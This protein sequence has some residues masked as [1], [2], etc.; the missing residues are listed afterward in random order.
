MRIVVTGGAGFIGS[1]FVRW[2]LESDPGASVVTLDALTYAGNAENL[3]G[4]DPDRHRLVV[5][6]VTR[7]D[8]V[9]G[10]LDGHVDAVVHFAAESHVDRSILGAQAFATTNVVGTQVVLDAVRAARVPRLLYVSTDE[11]Y[12]SLAPGDA[13][14]TEQHPLRPTSPYAASKAGADLLVLAAAATHG[15]D[16][17]I[18]RCGNNYGP[19]QFPEKLIPLF[20]TNALAGERLPLYGDGRQV[21]D[22]IHVHDHCR[23]LGT[24]LQRGRAGRVYNVGAHGERD[25]LAL[26]QQ[27]MA[28]LDV[29]EDR[30]VHVADRPAHDRRY[31]LDTR[32]I[33]DELGF[34]PV[35][36]LD[37]GLAATVAW[38]R[39]HRDWWERVK[40]G[41][42]RTYYAAQY[43][44]RLS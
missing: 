7:P 6:D 32:R 44:E 27:L 3:G 24:V 28:L 31:A 18:T 13:P 11:V 42:Y 39:E 5:G 15:L 40:S 29:G 4:L 43:G 17:V 20:I 12:G 1:N 37:E 33:Q 14:F 41:A 19:Y 10:V 26:A 36:P 25:N 22:W 21:R 38:Y 8:D 34:A 2:V 9:R 35:I 16:A 23:A 30:L